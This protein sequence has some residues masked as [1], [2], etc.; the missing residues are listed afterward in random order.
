MN[1]AFRDGMLQA[2]KML[3][4]RADHLT[5]LV[6]KTEAIDDK[7]CLINQTVALLTMGNEIVRACAKAEADVDEMKG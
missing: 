5:A 3:D 6:G 2:A 7:L 1:S 4:A